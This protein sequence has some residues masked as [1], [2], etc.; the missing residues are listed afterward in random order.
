M[1]TGRLGTIKG[2]KHCTYLKQGTATTQRQPFWQ[3]QLTREDIADQVKAMLDESVVEPA[4]TEWASPVVV[5][6]KKDASL[7]FCVEYRNL[8][9]VITVPD[10]YPF[11]R[12]LDCI[13]SL[14]EAV[15][16]TTLDAN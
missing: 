13:D 12:M 3:G 9:A 4:T 14:G 16:V 7:R 2:T 1:W 11:P 5:F 6:P 10:R 15:V 8:N